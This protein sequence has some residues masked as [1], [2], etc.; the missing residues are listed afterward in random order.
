M[1]KYR[2]LMLLGCV[3]A[4]ACLAPLAAQANPVVSLELTGVNGASLNQVNTAP[5]YAQIGP[6][7]LTQ[8]SQFNSSNSTSVAVYCDDFF[9]DVNVGQVWQATATNV[10]ALSTTVLDT[11]LM[12]NGGMTAATQATDYMAAA[13]LAEQIAGQNQALPL[14]QLTA[15]QDSYALWYIFDSSALSGLSPTDTSA[16]IADY[17]SAFAAVANDKPGDFFNVN[18]YTPVDHTPGSADS[19]EYLTVGVPEPDALAL[20]AVGL[21]AL[22]WATR[23]RRRAQ[24]I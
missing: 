9:D 18:I 1:H 3:V 23:R 16:I 11:N 2:N 19:Q 17:N 10:G 14:G 21:A 24:S 8:G 13:W 22:G 4:G 15:E 5:Y 7:G 6:S 12:F 20:M